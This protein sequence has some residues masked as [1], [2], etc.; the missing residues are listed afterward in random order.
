MPPCQLDFDEFRIQST[1]SRGIDIFH[2]S[3]NLSRLVA[4]M[5][6]SP[7]P[8]H[9]ELGVHLYSVVQTLLRYPA[10]DTGC[11]ITNEPTV[12][13]L[14]PMFA[15]IFARSIMDEAGVLV[16]G[17]TDARATLG[18]Y[19]ALVHELAR[20]SAFP[21]PTD[22]DALIKDTV[23]GRGNRVTDEVDDFKE[24]VDIEKH[25]SGSTMAR[26]ALLRRGLRPNGKPGVC[27]RP[28]EVGGAGGAGGEAVGVFATR[29]LVRDDV[30]TIFPCAF[31]AIT[32]NAKADQQVRLYRA[33][34]SRTPGPPDAVKFYSHVARV[35][36]TAISI[37]GRAKSRDPG[38]CAHLIRDAVVSEAAKTTTDLLAETKAFNCVL[39]TLAGASVVAIATRTI[40]PG[41]ELRLGYSAA[42]FAAVE[43]AKLEED[44]AERMLARPARPA[45]P[46]PITIEDAHRMIASM[47]CISKFLN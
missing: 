6:S 21:S 3:C 25:S 18:E 31:F 45:A 44:D 23:D 40:Q 29:M 39:T 32:S 8:A 4:D 33:H 19:G 42:F 35:E 43:E 17:R 37:S 9:D 15:T 27:L 14:P 22:L 26:L 38:A 41:E 10:I 34:R 20:E 12:D 24:Y 13:K 7:I 30:V 2:R 28:L 16:S 11:A 46:P 47:N 1:N 36:G 5:R